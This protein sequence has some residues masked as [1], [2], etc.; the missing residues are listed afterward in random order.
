[1]RKSLGVTQPSIDAAMK[2]V[3]EIEDPS[4]AEFARR[5]EGFL[6][7]FRWCT[8][9]IGAEL[10]WATAGVLGVF[11]ME[12]DPVR[13]D[14]DTVV[15]VVIGD[16]PP[17]YLAYEPADTWQDALRG[18]V[19]EMQR[20][21]DAAKAAGK[22]SDLIPVNVAPPPANAARLE[23]RLAFIRTQLLAVPAES[24]ESDT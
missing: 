6:T 19:D 15:W 8:R 24:L 18:Y 14:I 20:W 21:V 9:I 7:G 16:L 3:G 1:M 2:P 12:I 22:V 10:A 17:A 4:V 23:S 5:A 11:R 13:N